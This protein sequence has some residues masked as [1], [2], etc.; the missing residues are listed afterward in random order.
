MKRISIRLRLT[1][2]YMAILLASLSLFGI[3]AFVAMRK[4]IEKSVDE[5]LGGQADGVAEVMGRV[6]Q[7]EPAELQDELREHQA[8]REQADFLQVCDQGGRWIYRSRLMTHYDV[9]VPVKTSYAAYNVTSADLPLRVLVREINA[10]AQTY[11]IQ[12][13][14][15][16]DDFYDA[17]DR[18]KWMVLL[19]SPLVLVLASAGGYWLSGRALAPV[20]KITRAAEEINSN[21]LAKRLDLPRSGDELQRLSQTLNHMLDRLEVSFNRITQFTADASHELRTPLAL[22]RTTTEVSL[23]T[24]HTVTDYREAQ[25]EILAELEKTSSLVEKLML[26]AR[27]DAGVETLQRVPVNVA[28]CLRDACKDGQVLAEA[29]QVKFSAEIDGQDLIVQGDSHALHRL[30][31]TLIDNAVKYTPPGG[32]VTL[33]LRRS[34]GSAIAECRDTGIGVSA[35]D[36][37]HIFDR[38]YRADKARSREFGG[39]GL[40]LSIARWFAEAHGGSIEVQ[41][42]AGTGSVFRIRLPLLQG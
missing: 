24:S 34:N 1:A 30:F 7:Q 23:R 40:G 36:L 19:L 9:T 11:R 10:G 26:L 18:F 35:E 20:D 2:W 3:V 29:K 22:M 33:G 38:F 16:M 14:T 21:N 25:Q 5:N 17:V 32:S 41:S 13:A 8:L 6:L 37:P 28:E 4:G 15:P 31:L 39:V 12:V 27:A 42:T